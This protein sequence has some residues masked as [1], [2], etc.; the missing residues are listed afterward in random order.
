MMLSNLWS[1]LRNGVRAVFSRPTYAAV[2]T[3][4]LALGIGV[5]VAVYS[6]AEQTLFRQLPVPEPDRL[7]N[8]S[9]PGPRV[10]GRRDPFLM[11][12]GTPGGEP[13][14]GGPETLFSYPMFARRASIR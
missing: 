10:V 12:D 14:S 9:D 1:D 13:P 2:V 11:P 5:N 4:T 6:L 8:L 7:V 3:L